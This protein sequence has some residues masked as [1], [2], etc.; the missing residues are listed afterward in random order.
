MLVILIGPSILNHNAHA[1]LMKQFEIISSTSLL[2]LRLS[3]NCVIINGIVLIFKTFHSILVSACNIIATVSLLA[4][5]LIASYSLICDR[6]L[7]KCRI[8]VKFCCHPLCTGRHVQKT[9]LISSLKFI[10]ASS[11]QYLYCCHRCT[12]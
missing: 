7:T 3:R 4:L 1:S 5:Q 9:S 8:Y 2:V 12:Q 11:R 6:G 10:R